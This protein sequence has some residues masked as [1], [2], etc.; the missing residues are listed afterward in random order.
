MTKTWWV[1]TECGNKGCGSDQPFIGTATSV[2]R[3]CSA[4]A[5]DTQRK[6][7][8]IV[9]GYCI[10]CSECCTCVVN[11]PVQIRVCACVYNEISCVPSCWCAWM[12]CML[13]QATVM[14]VELPTS[15]SDSSLAVADGTI[16][17]LSR[18]R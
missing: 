15:S 2:P 17:R 4:H 3:T 13:L 8:I 7:V 18:G 6:V 12:I 5:T 11:L 16:G 9:T 10:C 1:G 14:A